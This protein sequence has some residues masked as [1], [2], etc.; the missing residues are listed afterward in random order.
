MMFKSQPLYLTRANDQRLFA[1]LVTGFI[2][3]LSSSCGQD[4]NS[5]SGDKPVELTASCGD[6][7][8]G[9]TAFCQAMT[10]YQQQCFSCHPT[11][12]DYK[13]E[14]AWIDSGLLV[15]GDIDQS[16]AT[17]RL[18]NY[19]SNMPL[20]GSALSAQDYQALKDWVNSASSR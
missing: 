8:V 18:I 4:F 9:N 3:L 12:A 14:K 1:I 13:D 17:N 16:K 10:I 7:R 2:F 11:W 20:G 19:G 15:P 5:N 6:G